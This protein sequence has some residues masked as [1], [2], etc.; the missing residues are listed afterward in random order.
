M[1]KYITLNLKLSNSQLNKLKL[2][3]KND[4]EV[5]LNIS[6]NLIGNYNDGTNFLHKLL[7]TDRQVSK[8]RKILANGSSANTKFSKPQLYKMQLGGFNGL[9][10][11]NTAEIIYKI[12]NKIKGL[13]N[14]M[15][16][17]KFD[18]LIKTA[19]VYRKIMPDFKNIL[20]SGIA[21]TNNEII[22]IMKIIKPLEKTE[23]L[24][25]GTTKKE[26]LSILLDH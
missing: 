8:I 23:I 17:D 24:L 4:A 15:S 25:K 16:H 20:G 11:L 22:D 18:E 19:D 1:T 12:P 5:T 21:L 13:S 3:T 9:D 7:L 10:L 6:S 26:D 14:K 2:R